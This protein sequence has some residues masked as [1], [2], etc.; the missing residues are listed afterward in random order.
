MQMLAAKEKVYLG[1]DDALD[2][3]RRVVTERSSLAT[4]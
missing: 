2:M 1:F 4:A 3:A